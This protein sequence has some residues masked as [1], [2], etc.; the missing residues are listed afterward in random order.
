[1]TIKFADGRPVPP[2]P[3]G[4]V[5]RR[6]MLKA[7]RRAF[8]QL[9]RRPPRQRAAASLPRPRASCAR[10]VVVARGR[11]GNSERDDGGGDGDGADSNP[12]SPPPPALARDIARRAL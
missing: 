5:D 3:T 1:M 9:R 10:V 6:A 11:D 12:P 4:H 2:R 8:D 7:F